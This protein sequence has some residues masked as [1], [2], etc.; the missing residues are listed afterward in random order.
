MK[1]KFLKRSDVLSGTDRA[2]FLYDTIALLKSG[3]YSTI[4]LLDLVNSF[5]F[6]EES[7]IAIWSATSMFIRDLHVLL[8]EQSDTER[9]NLERFINKM[10]EKSYS[11]LG[12]YTASN[13]AP[14]RQKLRQIVLPIAALIGIEEMISEAKKV[15]SRFSGSDYQPED[16]DHRVD[17][18]NLPAVLETVS[19]PF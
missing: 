6:S 11:D 9:R 13:E 10:I 15:L 17:V 16:V 5:D 12:M 7:D 2:G 8:V 19:W 1:D 3:Q 18:E 4:S 14:I